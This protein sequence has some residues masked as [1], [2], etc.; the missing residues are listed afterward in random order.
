L[1]LQKEITLRKDELTEKKLSSLY[2]G[3][4]TPSVLSSMELEKIIDTISKYYHFEN[5]IE[6]TIEVNPDDLSPSFIKYLS[7]SVFNRLSIGVQ[8]FFD[9]DLKMMNRAHNAQQADTAIK[10]VQDVGLE[11]ISI[12]LMYGSP[13]SNEMIWKEN[14]QKT[15]DLQVPHISSYALTVEPNTALNQWIK[16]KKIQKPDENRQNEDFYWMTQFLKSKGFEHYEISNFAKPNSYSKHNS[17][18]WQGK[19]YLGLGPSAH[20]FDGDKKR[21]WNVANNTKYIKN[22]M[23]G[24]LPSETENLSEYDRYNETIMLGLRTK[25]GVDLEKMKT[26]FSEFILEKFNQ[27]THSKIK[28]NHLIIEDGYLKI[29]ENNW[30]MADGI[31]SDLFLVE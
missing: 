18:Y 10:R 20:S 11:N 15:I 29:P 13:T 19:P 16:A 14:L 3:G 23:S 8:S 30:F 31:A 21:S 5:D 26:N 28:N 7:S 1:A 12:D 24:I 6:I 27:N 22:L 17:A 2:F 4:G 25:W 9:E